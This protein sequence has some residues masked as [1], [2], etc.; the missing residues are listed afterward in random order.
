MWVCCSVV[1]SGRLLCQF[2]SLRRWP[3]SCRDQRCFLGHILFGFFGNVLSAIV[4]ESPGG[5]GLRK[6]NHRGQWSSIRQLPL[7]PVRDSDVIPGSRP[8]RS[9]R[10]AFG[11]RSTRSGK[12]SLIGGRRPRR[13]LAPPHPPGSALQGG[14]RVEDGQ[15]SRR[16]ALTS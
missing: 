15:R 1:V 12:G 8:R 14:A 16:E 10:S 9:T 2:S 4:F 6:S 11:G 5:A 3:M 7:A 13:R